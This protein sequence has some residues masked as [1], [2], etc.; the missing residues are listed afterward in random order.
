MS[1][2]IH[3]K[4]IEAEKNGDKDGKVLYK[5]INNAVYGKEMI[6]KQNLRIKKNNLFKT[7]KQEKGIFKIEIFDK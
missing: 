4:I 7:R 2:S 5:L 1:N 3:K 6:E